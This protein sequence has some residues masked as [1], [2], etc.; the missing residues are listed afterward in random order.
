ME[1]I[2]IWCTHGELSAVQLFQF[3]GLKEEELIWLILP[4]VIFWYEAD[5]SGKPFRYFCIENDF[6]HEISITCHENRN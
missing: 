2:Q 4:F 1:I 5:V 3:D 6:L